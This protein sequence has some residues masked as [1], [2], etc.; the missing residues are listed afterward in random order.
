M[1]ELRGP[2]LSCVSAS[3]RGS[4]R[5]TNSVLRIVIEHLIG[6]EPEHEVLIRRKPMIETPI[7]QRLPVAPFIFE[8]VAKKKARQQC[9]RERG[10]A[11]LMG[12]VGSKEK[13]GLVPND[14]TTDRT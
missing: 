3:C 2:C 10:R 5:R 12:S 13:E 8:A 7:D 14:R 1:I 11:V 4:C 9:A 6:I